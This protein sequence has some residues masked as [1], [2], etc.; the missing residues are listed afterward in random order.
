MRLALV[1]MEPRFGDITHNITRACQLMENVHADLF[2]LPE[3]FNTGYNFLTIEELLALAEDDSGRTM[4]SMIEFAS[5]R[6]CYLVFGY[7]E[8]NTRQN[9]STYYNSSALIG[10]EGMVGKYRKVHLYY[11]ENLFFTPGD[12]GFP[13]FDLPFGKVGM[14]ICFDWIYPESARS[15]TLNGA[16]LI[17]HPSN[18]VLPYCPDGMII[19]SME[20]RVFTATADRVGYENR[21]DVNLTFIGTSQVVSNK[22]RI[23]ARC[24]DDTEEIAVVD[25]DLSR[26]DNKHL[27]EYNDLLNDRKYKQYHP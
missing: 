2:I 5:R 26:A 25:I 12:L 11:R 24:S 1:Q 13:V 20:N 4:Q 15:L 3:L 10:P 27:N 22:G 8:V 16:Q 18:L 14:M 17:A 23:L 21:G 9:G 19:R 6:S 7:A